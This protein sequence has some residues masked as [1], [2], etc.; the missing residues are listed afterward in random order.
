MSIAASWIGL[1]AA[2]F[3]WTVDWW[4]PPTITGTRIGVEDLLMSISHLGIGVFGYM[5]FFNKKTDAMFDLKSQFLFH[6]LQ[7]FALWFLLSFGTTVFFFHVLN[8]SS[9][10]STFVGMTVAA[11]YLLIKRLDLFMP[12][13]WTG[14]LFLI[15]AIPIYLITNIAFPGAVQQVWYINNLTGYIFFGIP[16]EDYIWYWMLGF[17]LGGAYPYLTKSKYVNVE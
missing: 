13:F 4:H 8:F 14:N 2:Y 12:M 3:W 16:L 6:F 1:W 7:R 15:I 17:F 9:F 11:I 10:V 5:V